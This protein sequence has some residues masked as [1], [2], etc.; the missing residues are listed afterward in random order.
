MKKKPAWYLGAVL[1]LGM[2]L[3]A[4]SCGGG[5]SAPA[6]E[7]EPTAAETVVEETVAEE[8]VVEETVVEETVVEETVVE[9]AVV[10]ETVVEE[11]TAIPHTLAGRDNC[12]QCHGESG[13]KP[14]P[15][16]HAGRDNDTCTTCHQ[17]AG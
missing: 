14:F 5:A 10:E 15:D 4:V 7:E 1:I 9:E 8:T 12:V 16:D 2:T 6:E 17:P 13:F 3:L 11:A